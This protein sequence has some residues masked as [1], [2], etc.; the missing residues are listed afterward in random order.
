MVVR[1]ENRIR[2]LL[3]YDVSCLIFHREDDL[4]ALLFALMPTVACNAHSCS[5]VHGT[6]R[7]D[8]VVGQAVSMVLWRLLTGLPVLERKEFIRV[9]YDDSFRFVTF[10]VLLLFFFLELFTAGAFSLALYAVIAYS[11]LAA[12]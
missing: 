12:I 3:G 8:V 1:D 2:H 10:P 9:E 6:F 5:D 11:D 7:R 4:E